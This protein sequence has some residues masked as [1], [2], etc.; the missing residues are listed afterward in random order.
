[1]QNVHPEKAESRE[2]GL[3][4]DYF[5]TFPLSSKKLL[6][7]TI[8]K[9]EKWVKYGSKSVPSDFEFKKTLNF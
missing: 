5:Y 6:Q 7:L 1:M 4:L 3:V 2:T 8:S 9:N